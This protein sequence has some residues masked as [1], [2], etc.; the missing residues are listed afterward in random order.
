VCVCV[1]VRER[2]RV[3][4]CVS[5]AHLIRAPGMFWLYQSRHIERPD[6]LR[7]GTSASD[8][9]LLVCGMSD[10]SKLWGGTFC[11]TDQSQTGTCVE[12]ALQTVIIVLI[13]CPSSS[14]LWQ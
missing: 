6:L 9:A 3:C 8:D 13:S 5:T 7:S 12:T 2:E 1:C 14:C 4:M 10:L 11:L